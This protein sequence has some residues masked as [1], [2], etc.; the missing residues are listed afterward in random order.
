MTIRLNKEKVL[1]ISTVF[2]RD[3]LELA[4]KPI[5]VI[6]KD[7]DFF[8]LEKPYNGITRINKSFCSCSFS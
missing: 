3:L 4:E 2:K 5:P 8:L 7:E 6:A 1:K